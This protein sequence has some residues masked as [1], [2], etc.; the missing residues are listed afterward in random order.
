MLCI[1]NTARGDERFPPA[2]FGKILAIPVGRAPI[3]DRYVA[4]V[5]PTSTTE[6]SA[7]H[8]PACEPLPPRR[9]LGNRYVYCVLSQRAGGL[10]IGINLNPDQHCNFDCVY[11]EIDRSARPK[12]RRLHIPRMIAELESMLGLVHS[13]RFEELGYS[14]APELLPFKEV[15][16]SGDGE[17]TLCPEFRQAVEAIVHLRARHRF[18][19]FKIVLITNTT[20]LPLPEV[21]KGIELLAAE[22]EIWAKLDAGTQEYMDIVNRPNISIEDVMENILSVARRRPVIIQ[23]LIP[24]INGREPPDDEI[25]ELAA[26]LRELRE[27]GAKI[28]LVQIYSA[29]RP[30]MDATCAHL[31]LRSLSRIAKTIRKVSGLS[32]EVF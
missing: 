18:P 24:L 30:A 16:L 27:D 22:D 26:R 5:F 13:G 4:F 28:P 17:P 25:L 31:P 1:A 2:K 29:H 6:T 12:H 19:F 14:A 10:S 15:A 9:F 7:P 8:P 11:C 20:G 32:A 3:G 21:R 23:S